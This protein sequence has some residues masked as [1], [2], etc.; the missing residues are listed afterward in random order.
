[1]RRK[2]DA[3]KFALAGREPQ[4]QAVMSRTAGQMSKQEARRIHVG[5]GRQG[6]AGAGS[7]EQA[8]RVRFCAG[9]QT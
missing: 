1:L 7:H 5:S 4:A 2:P 8:V 6:T 3:V 9:N